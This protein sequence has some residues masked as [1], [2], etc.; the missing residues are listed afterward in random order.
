M[1]PG[2]WG[3]EAGPSS[4]VSDAIRRVAS[5]SNPVSPVIVRQILTRLRQ[6]GAES[7]KPKVASAPLLSAREKEVLDLIT[8]GFK[9]HE[10]AELTQ[11]SPFTVKTYMR[12]IYS[13]LNVTSKAE[14]IYE[15]RTL[16]LLS[17]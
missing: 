12:R 17:D 15:A 13:K 7:S 1:R 4:C 2:C 14:A 8:K 11:L 10:I 16:G 9:A 5:G 6:S 3:P